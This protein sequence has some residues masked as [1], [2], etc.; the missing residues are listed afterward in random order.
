MQQDSESLNLEYVLSTVRR[1]LPLLVLCFAVVT[2]TA[3]LYSK[4]QTKKYTATASLIFND[5]SLN[6][7]LVGL[8]ANTSN[9]LVR[10]A[11]NVVSVQLGDMAAKT[12]VLL[13]HGL[14]EEKVKSSIKVNSLGE[15]SSVAVSATATSPPLAAKIANTYATQFVIEQDTANRRFFRSALTLVNKQLAEMPKRQRFGPSGVALE[16]RAQSLRF[17]SELQGNSVSFAQAAPTPTSPSSPKIFRNTLLGGVLGLL[18]GFGLVILLERL[19]RRRRITEPMDL[20]T[21]YGAAL[22]G[23]VPESPP[24]TQS[25]HRHGHTLSLTEIETFN[26]IRAHMRSFNANRNPHTV[27][28]VSPASGEGRTTIARHIAEAAARL[29]SRTLLIEADLRHPVLAQQ[30]DV[31][32]RA[33]LPEV[34]IGAASTEEATCSIELAAPFNERPEHRTLDVLLAGIEPTPNPG[35]LMD[36]HAMETVLERARSAYDFVIIDTPPLGTFSDTFPLLQKA[37]GMIVVGRIGSQRDAAERLHKIVGSSAMPLL[38]VIANGA[39]M[40]GWTSPK[41]TYTSTIATEASASS[42]AQANGATPSDSL[43]SPTANV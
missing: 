9:L 23:I 12:A 5:N 28:V 24:L 29:G 41:R 34:L 1:R 35:A 13:G 39:K 42:A 2:A 33:Y 22:L 25:P 16:N 3:F 40:T 36:S 31:P 4:Q 10:E 11:G 15:S 6:Q 18:I 43:V 19:D 7:E 20:E 32:P 37:D 21:I 14:T 38:G 27:L 17:L 8:P 30:L 26:L